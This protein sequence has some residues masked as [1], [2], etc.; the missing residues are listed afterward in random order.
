MNALDEF[1]VENDQKTC[2]SHDG[3][4]TTKVW[5]GYGSGIGIDILGRIGYGLGTG[6]GIKY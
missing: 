4:A 2:K 3:S 5:V 1:G 6:I